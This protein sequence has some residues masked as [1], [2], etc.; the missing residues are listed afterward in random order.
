[1]MLY[2]DVNHLNTLLLHFIVVPKD[3]ESQDQGHELQGKGQHQEVLADIDI[4]TR[5][6]NIE[7]D[8]FLIYLYAL[9]YEHTVHK[10]MYQL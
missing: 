8:T 10:I 1:M 9:L 5:K 6:I 4:N 7:T 3:Q 2:C